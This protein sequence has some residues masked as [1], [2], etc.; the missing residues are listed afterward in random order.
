MID[1]IQVFVIAAA[2]VSII[3]PLFLWLRSE[4]NED[5]REFRT[6]LN[7]HRTEIAE[8]TVA[9]YKETQKIREDM[10]AESRDFHGRLCAIEERR[11]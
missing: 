2:N 9:F 10:Q 7:A 4:A 3:V 8:I 6:E 5:R 11:K 1:W